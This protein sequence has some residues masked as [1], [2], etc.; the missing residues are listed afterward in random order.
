MILKWNKINQQ[1]QHQQQQ[2]SQ[3][4]AATPG[5][6]AH[7]LAAVLMEHDPDTFRWVYSQIKLILFLHCWFILF[8]FKIILDDALLATY[9]FRSFLADVR[10]C[11]LVDFYIFMENKRVFSGL[12]CTSM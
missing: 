3:V 6:H 7:N 8:H 9:L 12:S 11:L 10:L 5:L 1:Q 2:Q 4:M